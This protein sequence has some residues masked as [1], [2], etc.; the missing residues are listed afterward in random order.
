MHVLFGHLK[1]GNG[2][3]SEGEENASRSH[4]AMYSP[5]AREAMT[6]ETRGQN[7]WVNYG[8]D[9]ATNRTASAADTQYAS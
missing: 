2:F 9:G 7:S 8:P 5:P 6:I 1:E 4:S 3:R